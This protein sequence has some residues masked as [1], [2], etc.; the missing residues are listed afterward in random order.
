M[1]L[2]RREWMIGL[3]FG[4]DH[5]QLSYY[6][7][8]MREPQTAGEGEADYLIEVP[9]EVWQD[10][11]ASGVEPE[12]VSDFFAACLERVPGL[13]D[14]KDVRI[15]VTVPS[16]EGPVFE[17]AVQA[18][19]M[20]GIER[21]HIFVQDHQ[22]S[23]YYYAVNQ[24]RELWSGD[25]ALIEYRDGCMSGWV[26]H[27]DRAKMP[28]VVSVKK[29]ASVTIDDSV[30]G[31]RD[32]EEWDKER[33]RQFFELL[34]RVFER[35]NVVTCYLL[36]TYFDRKWAVRSFQ[37][38]C[39]HRHAFQGGNLYTKGACY[40]AMERMGLLKMPQMVF[41]GSQVVRDN[42][43]IQLKVR[44]KEVYYPLIN[45]GENWYEAF[46]ECEIIPDDERS[47]TIV[48]R[49]MTGG[50]QVSHVLRL[51]DFPQRPKRAS[52][53]KLSVY[54]TSPEQAVVELEDLGFGGFFRPSGRVWKRAI[55]LPS[56]PEEE[57]SVDEL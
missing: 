39:F 8:S 48:S 53:L 34:K 15:M 51:K 49:P 50:A 55:Y 20:L 3:E 47:L 23:F 36:G 56:E 16:L 11:A 44:G 29:A 52:R 12:K 26:M 42:L 45:A 41:L 7:S 14:P 5:A 19:E 22:S 6:Q 32:D 1:A 35:R 54:L 37:Y 21:K 10:A 43:G 18:L 30:R 57:A 27:I 24:K 13:S 28:P 38:L 9:G 25:V 4:P 40:G 33:D 31:G 2:N 46:C 17:R